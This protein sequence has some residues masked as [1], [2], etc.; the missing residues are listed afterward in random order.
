MRKALAISTI[1]LASCAAPVAVLEN[2]PHLPQP[3]DDV[4]S[5]AAV[6]TAAVPVVRWL[7]RAVLRLVTNTTVNVDIKKTD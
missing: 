3:G 1:V 4:A 6:G 2:D 7:G 5:G